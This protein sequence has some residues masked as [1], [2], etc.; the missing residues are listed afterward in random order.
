VIQEELEVGT[1]VVDTGVV[2]IRKVISN[3]EAVVD[4]SIVQ[5]DVVI[6]RIPLNRPVDPAAVPDVRQE[7]DTLIIP[8]I[9]E[10][11]V[12]EKRLFLR[13]EVRISRVGREVPTQ[14]RVSLREERVVV[15]REEEAEPN[16]ALPDQHE[17]ETS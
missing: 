13:E 8:V 15:E 16:Q 17:G 5:R 10:T 12:V 7:G 14:T 2:R 3:R 6:E 4:D 9:E 1:R 11:L